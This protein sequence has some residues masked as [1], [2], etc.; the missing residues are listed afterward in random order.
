MTSD[1]TVIINLFYVMPLQNIS[2]FATVWADIMKNVQDL[3]FKKNKPIA[4]CETC[5][6]KLRPNLAVK[7]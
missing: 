4:E 1:Q 6:N 2:G 3:G 7:H 5:E